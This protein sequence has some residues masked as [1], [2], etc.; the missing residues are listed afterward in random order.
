MRS[1][2]SPGSGYKIGDQ[3]EAPLPYGRG[4]MRAVAALWETSRLFGS[5]RVRTPRRQMMHAVV[6]VAP[7]GRGPATTWDLG[8]AGKGLIGVEKRGEADGPKLAAERAAELTRPMPKSWS[9]P[10]A[11]FNGKDLSGW[12]PIGNVQNN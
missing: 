2:R 9:A 8:V 11:I 6:T 3:C 5:P 1:Q 12:E 4:S 7:V 10:E